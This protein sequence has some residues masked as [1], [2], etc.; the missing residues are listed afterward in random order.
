[1]S[2]FSEPFTFPSIAH[3]LQIDF[4]CFG[5]GFACPQFLPGWSQAR[6][7]LVRIS[8]SLLDLQGLSF[9]SGQLERCEK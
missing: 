2:T 8:C 5:A 9:S 3:H 4:R 7:I 1:M 6:G